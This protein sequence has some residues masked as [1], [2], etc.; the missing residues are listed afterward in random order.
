MGGA[1]TIKLE[2]MMHETTK[3]LQK[4]EDV[5]QSPLLN[6]FLCPMP[7]CWSKFLCGEKMLSLHKITMIFK[8]SSQLFVV[9]RFYLLDVNK[10]CSYFHE[11]QEQ[12]NC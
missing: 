12:S 3:I 10:T 2:F 8:V 9:S 1:T 7:S 11:E 6:G 4:Q 5:K